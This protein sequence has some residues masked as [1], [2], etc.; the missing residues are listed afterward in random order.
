M[1]VCLGNGPPCSVNR[2]VAVRR[3]STQRRH[4]CTVSSPAELPIEFRPT[5]FG[6][7]HG[8]CLSNFLKRQ[9][10]AKQLPSFEVCQVQKGWG[11]AVRLEKA[12]HVPIK[13]Q[14]FIIVFICGPNLVLLSRSQT[15]T[16]A[17]T[18]IHVTLYTIITV[19]GNLHCY[20]LL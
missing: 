17:L 12:I 11:S 19:Q 2:L 16:L 20:I 4:L 15:D 13:Q 7:F 1:C 18:S 14:E 10:P 8:W 5:Q 6:L 9:E 3:R